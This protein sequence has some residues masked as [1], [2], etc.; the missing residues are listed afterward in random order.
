MGVLAA[1]VKLLKTGEG[2]RVE[3]NLYNAGID[4]QGEAWLPI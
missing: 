2:T 4:L 3:S 1:F